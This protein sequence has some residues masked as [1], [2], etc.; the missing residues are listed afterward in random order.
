MF[1]R[2]LARDVA[3]KALRWASLVL[4][5]AGSTAMAA[6]FRSA[7]YGIATHVL[8][9]QFLFALIPA[10]AAAALLWSGDSPKKNRVLPAHAILLTLL[11]VC[12]SESWC[13][14]EESA[15]RSEA[16]ARAE[17][18]YSRARWFPYGA[19]GLM[20]SDGSFAA[21]D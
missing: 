16:K 12:V 14:I 9:A 3:M 1:R 18:T 15:F 13:A 21:H 7:T 10:V 19:H 8:A 20:F 6:W 11:C 17:V 4:L 5:L 2:V